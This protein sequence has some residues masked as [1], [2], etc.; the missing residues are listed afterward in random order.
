MAADPN[1]QA[2]PRVGLAMT[3]PQSMVSHH[4]APCFLAVDDEALTFGPERA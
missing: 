4:G 3:S 2:P 1:P